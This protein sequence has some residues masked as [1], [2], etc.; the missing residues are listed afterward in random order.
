MSN[1]LEGGIVSRGEDDERASQRKAAAD[2]RAIADMLD[3]GKIAGIIIAAA[4]SIDLIDGRDAST[5]YLVSTAGAPDAMPNLFKAVRKA[6]D[7][8]FKD[9]P[10]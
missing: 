7:E 9:T 3:D 6:D 5:A 4:V 8:H 2:C 10:R 1:D